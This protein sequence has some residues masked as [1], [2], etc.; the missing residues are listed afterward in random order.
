MFLEPGFLTG[1][2]LSDLAGWLTSNPL[3]SSSYVYVQSIGMIGMYHHT[4]LLS[5]Y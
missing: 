2:E 5:R 3:V 4:R 1:R